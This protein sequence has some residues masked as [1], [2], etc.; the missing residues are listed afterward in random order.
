MACVY[1]LC[2]S[3]PYSDSQRMATCL[4]EAYRCCSRPWLGAGCTTL[5]GILQPP[6]FFRRLLR[7]PPHTAKKASIPLASAT[8]TIIMRRCMTGVAFFFGCTVSSLT[9]A[10]FFF[11]ISLELPFAFFRCVRHRPRPCDWLFVRFRVAF[12]L[13]FSKRVNIWGR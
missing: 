2:S 4:K 8:S 13:L 7:C 6:A 1:I 10:H 3:L 11:L 12:F 9:G 5:S